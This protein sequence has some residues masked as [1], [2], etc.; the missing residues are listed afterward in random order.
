M[1]VL[2]LGR[3]AGSGVG[4]VPKY[5]TVVG[6]SASRNAARDLRRPL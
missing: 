3:F 6:V 4:N 1:T 5:P 2:K